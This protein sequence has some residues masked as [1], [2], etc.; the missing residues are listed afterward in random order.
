MVSQVLIW[1]KFVKL[2]LNALLENLLNM[3]L[4]LKLQK[5]SI[6]MKILKWTLI[7]FQKSKDLTSKNLLRLLESLLDTLILKNMKCSKENSI[8]LTD[9]KETDKNNKA[10]VFKL[11]GIMTMEITVIITWKKNLMKMIFIAEFIV[12]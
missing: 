11:T 9:N 3:K 2:L 7:L 1:P 12:I 10:M 8:L 6:Q 5:N 4:E